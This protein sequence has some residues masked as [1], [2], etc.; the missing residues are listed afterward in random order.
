MRTA[1]LGLA[2]TFAISCGLLLALPVLA[3]AA[4]AGAPA[5]D[6]KLLQITAHAAGIAVA[7]RGIVAILKSPIGGLFWLKVPVAV[8]LLVLAALCALAVGFESLAAGRPVLEAIFVAIGGLGGAITTHE[9]QDRLLP[10][11]RL[12]P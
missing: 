1:T 7:I 9:L 6:P 10:G 5:L 11:P 8:R 3:Q 12:R 2:L 4:A